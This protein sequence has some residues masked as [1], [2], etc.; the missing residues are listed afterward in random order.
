[1]GEGLRLLTWGFMDMVMKEGLEGEKVL[2]TVSFVVAMVYQLSQGFRGLQNWAGGTSTRSWW[3]LRPPYWASSP[4]WALH[5]TPGASGTTGGLLG[6]FLEGGGLH[7][8]EAQSEMGVKTQLR[9]ESSEIRVCGPRQGC[10]WLRGPGLGP[11][12][13]LSAWIN[14]WVPPSVIGGRNHTWEWF[15][16]VTWAS[17]ALWALLVTVC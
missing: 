13:A 6:L 12:R 1:M 11:L 16:A 2:E 10:L 9:S 14:L 15:W 17:G 8:G 3:A 4:H 5:L 7:T